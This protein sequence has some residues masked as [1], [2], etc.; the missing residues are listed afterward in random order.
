MGD[1]MQTLQADTRTEPERTI[2]GRNGSAGHR[3][4]T[5]DREGLERRVARLGWLSIGLGAAQLL[6]P[7]TM[8]R[9]I[10]ARPRRNTRATMVAVGLREIACGAGILATAGAAPWLW[11]RVAGDLMDAALL[12]K[13]LGGRRT[14]STRLAGAIASV[15]GIGAIDAKLA[16]DA[17]RHGP[18]AARRAAIHVART[19]TINRF[20]EDVYR[21]WRDFENLP[22]FMAHLESVETN[23][24]RSRWRAKGPAGVGIEWEAEIEGDR[25]NEFIAWR[26]CPG[27]SV[28][29]E[30]FVSFLPAPGGRGTEV[31]VE[32]QY[33]PPAGAIGAAVAK[34]FGRE[35]SQQIA[36][37]L[38][39]FKQVIETGE[40]VHSDA[41]IH[42]WPHPARP[43]KPSE[44][45]GK[46]VQR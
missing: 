45:D 37:D 1:T 5:A 20:P 10:G 30:G 7:N 8:A 28:A 26:S 44:I 4:S 46:E 2:S 36:G 34:L 23:G 16:F 13:T 15:A 33:R 41:S 27:A 38:R 22:R 9:A 42:R 31:R 14:N 39:R 40:V 29:N 6:A 35:P 21:F 19:I 17:T 32:L 25:P 11:L 12:G 18:I 24:R 43:P 3:A